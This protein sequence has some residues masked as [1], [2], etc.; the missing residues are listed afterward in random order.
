MTVGALGYQTIWNTGVESVWG[1]AVI[2]DRS[3][4]LLPSESIERKPVVITR[5]GMRGG[6][7]AAFPETRRI[8]TGQTVDG[9]VDLEVLPVSMGRFFQQLMG[10]TPTFTQVGA[11][12]AW[13]HV[14]GLGPVSGASRSLTIQK[15]V[16]DPAQTVVQTLTQSG[17]KIT[18]G[19]FSIAAN[20][21]LALKMAIDGRQE[22][23]TTAAAAAAYAASNV[24]P[25]HFAQ[26]TLSVNGSPVLNVGT[27][28]V[29]VDRKL[30]VDRR[31]L[32]NLGFKDEQVEDNRPALSGSLTGDV[33][34]VTLYNLFATDGGG[35]LTLT[36]TGGPVTG[37]P[38]SNNTLTITVPL[39][40]LTAG[41]PK[42]STPGLLSE[43]YPW[44]SDAGG[45]TIT[46]LTSDVA[47]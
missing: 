8:I 2:P 32:G 3:Y 25:F 41:T 13:T 27:A 30:K 24:D 34:D 18:S 17:C 19:E 26:A 36:F 39:I 33:I 6:S 35:T 10:G 43:A 20:G 9:S 29:K 12:P 47:A 38:A 37:A 45:A 40:H 1:T 14:Y 44:V 28:T 15:V 46:Y 23:T 42:V 21:L 5:G 31:Y 16:R 7:L 11:T 22:V 4:E